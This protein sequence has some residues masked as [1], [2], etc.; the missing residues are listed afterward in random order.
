MRL[1]AVAVLV[2]AATAIAGARGLTGVQ[3][4]PR[5]QF[6]NDNNAV[7]GEPD[8]SYRWQSALDGKVNGALSVIDGTIYVETFNHKLYAIDA[9]TGKTTWVHALDGVAMNAPVV[10]NGIVIAGTGTSHRLSEDELHVVIGDPGADSVSGFDSQTG[11]LL[12]RYRTVGEDMP[13]GV[14]TL[15]GNTPAFIFS[16]GDAHVYALDPATGALLWK[17]R[18]PGESTM[19][20]LA[21][22]QGR[23]YGLSMVLTSSAYAERTF[24]NASPTVPERYRYT[25]ALDPASRQFVWLDQ[26]GYTDC[27]PAIGDGLVFVES[28]FW[29]GHGTGYNIVYAA[30]A[31]SGALRWKYKSSVGPQPVSASHELAI[32]G[33]YDSGRFFESLPFAREFDAFDA[34][35]GSVLWKV[36][37]H[38]AVQMSAVADKGF[39]Y[40]GDI[41]GDLYVLDEATGK[42]VRELRFPNMFTT[43]PPVIVGNTMFIVNFSTLYA[44]RLSD[45]F[46]GTL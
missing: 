31:A 18:T 42:V 26:F 41:A 5:Y 23:V 1:L 33:T 8:W 14:L 44:V 27:S 43:S 46:S 10:A 36:K 2:A 38:D 37:T 35:S 28:T 15:A 12:W 40:V 7:F 16:N 45:L 13:T 24:V 32:A 17:R 11:A 22:Y 30:D 19:S 9:Q 25:W 21:E 4:W 6:S 39:V 29:A 20:S 3:S 34:R